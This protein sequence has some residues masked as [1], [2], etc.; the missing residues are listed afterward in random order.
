MA[1]QPPDQMRED[2][3]IDVGLDFIRDHRLPAFLEVL[4][5]WWIALFRLVHYSLIYTCTYYLPA[6]PTPAKATIQRIPLMTHARIRKS[7][8]ETASTLHEQ[9]VKKL[10]EL[11][12]EA[13][14]SSKSTLSSALS[15]TP[16]RLVTLIRSDATLRRLVSE[17]MMTPGAEYTQLY[18]QLDDIWSELLP[19]PSIKLLDASAATADAHGKRSWKHSLIL[20]AYRERG[21]TIVHTLQCA[22]E[23]CR[24]PANIQVVVVDA[25]HCT[26][27]EAID[28]LPTISDS[29]SSSNGNGIHGSNSS[30]HQWGEIKLVHTSGGGRGPT[31]NYGADCTNGTI[32]T[33]LH[34]D[35]ILPADWDAKIQATLVP[36]SSRDQSSSSSVVH[37]CAFS[38]GTNLSVQ[39]LE[40]M[41]FPWGIQAVHFTVGLRTSRLKLPYGDNVISIPTTYFKY[42]GGFPNQPIMEDY[43]LMDLLRTRAKVL[44]ETLVI[45]PESTVSRRAMLRHAVALC[46]RGS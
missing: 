42:I 27:L 22:L 28:K 17:L 5:S 16:N 33:F 44:P 14:S 30:N 2:T 38:F 3:W 36:S 40:G 39:G 41:G 45:V 24:D 32:L 10:K 7:V 19:L 9:L 13:D 25:G 46:T 11:S 43:S 29:H 6:Q 4:I 31:L 1:N 18:K 26:D 34:S 20:P 21:Q 35:V 8:D 37:A 15:G 12:T 23:S